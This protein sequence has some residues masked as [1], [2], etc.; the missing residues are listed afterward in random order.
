[1][2]QTEGLAVSGIQADVNPWDDGNLV[3][4]CETEVAICEILPARC[5]KAIA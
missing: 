4:M 2:D 5:R 3:V 1:M